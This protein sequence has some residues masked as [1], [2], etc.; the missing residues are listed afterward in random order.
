[1]KLVKLKAINFGSFKELEYDFV[2]HP[3]LIQGENLSDENQESNGSGK[4]FV[5]AA[6]EFCLFKSTSRNVRDVEL[7]H[8][9]ELKCEVSLEVVCDLRNELLKIER[10][11]N[12][13][14]GE[15]QVS[16]N[17]KVIYSF[18]DKMAAN[19][20]K[21]IIDWIGISKE[22]LQNYYIINKERYR[23]IFSSSNREKVELIN[24]F[25]NASLIKGVD[26]F[27]I[28][29]TGTIQLKINEIERNIVQKQSSIET[30]QSEIQSELDRDIEGEKKKRI[31]GLEQQIEVRLISISDEQ[32]SIKTYSKSKLDALSSV[33]ELES[34]LKKINE[35]ISNFNGVD[36]SGEILVI[37]KEIE[38]LETQS[39]EIEDN[40]KADQLEVR[41]IEKS[42]SEIEKSLMGKITC[43]NCSH[44][45]IPGKEIDINQATQEKYESEELIKLLSKSIELTSSKIDEFE[46]QILNLFKKRDLVKS[47][48][49]F[50]DRWDIRLKKIRRSIND[51]LDS[52]NT[53]I[54]TFETKIKFCNSRIEKFTNEINLFKQELVTVNNLSIDRE[55]INSIN[56][57]IGRT[58]EEIDL[59]NSNL[60]QTK[61][62]LFFIQQWITNFKKFD[63]FLAN[64]SL[65]VIQGYC[66]KFLQDLKSDI[67]VK[68][69]G[70]KVLASG[71]T[72]DEVTSYILR[73]GKQRNFWS[74]SGGERAR[75]EYAMIFTL[76][77]M[78]NKTHKYSGLD[79]LSTDEIAEGI[80]AQGLS[81]LMKS[82][83]QNKSVLLTTHVVNKNVSENILLVRK[84]DGVSNLVN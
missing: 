55:R 33:P 13:K 26:R 77:E 75:M 61:E 73:D 30:L 68:W 27:V 15:S 78:I 41:Q 83:P 65:K 44:E 2:N 45:F 58:S 81:D 16:V 76:Q 74:F 64:N 63:M 24:R 28:E 67:Q 32:S 3:V 22:D 10:R 51:Q 48:T 1:M 84:V 9:D 11:I 40:V 39:K 19:C 38:N 46:K 57:K 8:G 70:R 35:I 23:S 66:N 79:F 20:D 36:V 5:T 49:R 17:G 53:I 56:E 43:P 6:I 12:R 7:I 60:I 14:G 62:E 47:K 4:S 37:N 34:K 21:Y 59:L 80:D 18:D 69:E 82:L 52:I 42:I 31:E 71:E 54:S 29:E 50:N 25:S 72:R